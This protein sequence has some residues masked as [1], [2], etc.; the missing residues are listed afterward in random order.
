MNRIMVFI[1][2]G[3]LFCGVIDGN[4]GDFYNLN[5]DT[6]ITKIARKR[7][8]IRVYYYTVRPTDK[9]AQNF[10]RQLAFIDQL[11]RKP[12]FKVRFGR[13]AGPVGAQR[14][15]GTDIHLAVDMLSLAHNNAFDVAALVSGDGDFAEVINSVQSMGKI[16][17]NYAFHKRKSDHL[18]K[19]CDVF[20]YIDETYFK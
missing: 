7:K 9:N 18:L 5:I 17:E 14:E 12:Y 4:M 20:S 19:T 10:Q 15:K 16:V 11:E 6:F 13:L 3:N 8:L 1:D 2:G